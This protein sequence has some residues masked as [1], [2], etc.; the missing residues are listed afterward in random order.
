MK[1]ILIAT[2]GS[3]ASAAAIEEGLE[4]AE[5][6]EAAVTFV[7][8]KAP[9]PS[10]LGEP[11]Y[12]HAISHETIAAHEAVD[13]AMARAEANGIEADYDILEGEPVEKI[14]RVAMSRDV[15]MIVLGSRGLGAFKGA[16]L[17]S[18]SRGVVREADRPVLIARA[19]SR[20]PVAA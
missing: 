19:E 9:P 20:A 7:Y 5:A 10:M 2:D 1:R 8:V 15:D 16:L 18:V 11:Y 12:Q 14:L 3:E 4:L 17:G 13:I 6:L